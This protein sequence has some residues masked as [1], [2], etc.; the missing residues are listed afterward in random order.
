MRR[1]WRAFAL[2]W[3]LFLIAVLV[4][5]AWR[6]LDPPDPARPW[7]VQALLKTALLLISLLALTLSDGTWAEWGFRRPEKPRWGPSLLRGGLLGAASSALIILTPARGMVWLRDL[8]LVGLVVWV[9]I[10]SSVTEEIF[11]RGWFQGFVRP[12]NGP[13]RLGPWELE[14]G[15]ALSALLFGSMHLTILRNGADPWT[16]AVIVLAT[17]ALGWCAADDR[18]RTGSLGPP[19]ATHVAF[20]LGGFL[21]AVLT[22]AISVAITGQPPSV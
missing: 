19:I 20:N 13:L 15:R 14:P 8:G 9:W 18:V 3:G 11:V 7:L 22:T 2:A 16:V 12:G 5:E 4:P 10:Y 1:P 6:W 21:G 17:T